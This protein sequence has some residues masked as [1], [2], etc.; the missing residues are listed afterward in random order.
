[1]PLKQNIYASVC[2]WTWSYRLQADVAAG[3]LLAQQGKG[4]R[5][6]GRWVERWR[7]KGT[8]GVGGRVGGGAVRRDLLTEIPHDSQGQ[9]K[10]P[11]LT[12]LHRSVIG[13]DVDLG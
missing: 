3:I 13:T 2:M 6:G 11:R 9:Q 10:W 4:E 12:G 1:M 8:R 5:G 7:G